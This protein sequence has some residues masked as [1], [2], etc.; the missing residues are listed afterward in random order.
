MSLLLLLTLLLHAVL[1]HIH[2]GLS[3][4]FHGRYRLLVLQL[5]L[6]TVKLLTCR[7]GR[8]T[9]LGGVVDVRDGNLGSV[10][11]V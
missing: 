1:L 7:N 8:N 3:F 2:L 4:G 11:L 6:H 5:L 10:V 9:L